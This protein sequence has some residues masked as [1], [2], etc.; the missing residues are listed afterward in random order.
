MYFAGAIASG[1]FVTRIGD[2]YGRK[3]PTL[4]S[5]IISI[6]I[7][8]GLMISTNLNFSIV[9]FFLF[10]M[11]RPGKMQVGFLYVLRARLERFRRK[12]GSFILFFDGT[13]FLLFALYFKYI[14]KDWLYF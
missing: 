10:G 7:H 6:P 4:L 11:T 14:S 9:L 12:V 5:A 8:L 1:V 2:L 13:S 3:I